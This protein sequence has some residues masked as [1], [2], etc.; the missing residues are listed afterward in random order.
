MAHWPKGSS[1]VASMISWYCSW[2]PLNTNKSLNGLHTFKSHSLLKKQVATPQWFWCDK[3]ISRS[4]TSCGFQ[5]WKLRMMHKSNVW[6]IWDKIWIFISK[7]KFLF[8]HLRTY[9]EI[10]V[11]IEQINITKILNKNDAIVFI[12]FF[13]NN[14]QNY[15]CKH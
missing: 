8:S 9:T 14:H 13:Y 3:D 1:R 11:M 4:V 6:F 15:E 5:R 12:V 7:T 2:K 10:N